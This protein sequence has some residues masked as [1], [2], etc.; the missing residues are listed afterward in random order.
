[1]S[2]CDPKRTSNALGSRSKSS[3]AQYFIRCLLA[4][5][6]RKANMSAARLGLQSAR[7]GGIP[8]KEIPMQYRTIFIIAAATIVGMACV[9]NDALA[10]GG[11][12]AGGFHAGGAD[13]AG[14]VNRAGV[15]RAGVYHGGAYAGAYR[16]GVYGAGWRPGVGAAAAGTAAFGAAAVGAAAAGRYYN[17]CGYYPYPPCY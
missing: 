5:I 3:G 9:T 7:A 4:E 16:G 17:S 14:S 13:R 15:N 8:M 10:R 12:R 6:A 2:A 11:G 1:M